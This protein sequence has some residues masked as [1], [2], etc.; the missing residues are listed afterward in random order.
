MSF[1]HHNIGFIG[2]GNMGEAIIA[3]L[4]AAGMCAPEKIFFF[5][6]NRDRSQALRL[7]YG[8]VLLASEAAIVD[9]ADIIVFAVKPQ[10]IKPVLAA[11]AG[12][13]LFA[14]TTGRKLILSIAAGIRISM[15]E[16]YVYR[17]IDAAKQARLPI[18]RSMPNT[19][20]LVRSGMTGLCANCHATAEDIAVIRQLLSAIGQIIDCTENEMD[21]VTAVSGSG[22]A[23]CFYLAEAMIAA[24]TQLGFSPAV[25][26]E[27]TVN[28]FKGAVALL[29][30]RGESP[31]TLRGKVTSPGGTTEA[32]IRVLDDHFVKQAFVSAILAA[33]RRSKE[34]SD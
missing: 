2:A 14:D 4:M 27:L 34:L 8:V 1:L 13:H 20:A 29:E 15:F 26:A 25:A 31:E 32:A 10:I 18:L 7:R 11:M 21:A 12:Q 9:T 19:P 17:D 23:Y 28:T 5:D 3:G 24:G 30:Q 6:V 16:E 33:A 22:P